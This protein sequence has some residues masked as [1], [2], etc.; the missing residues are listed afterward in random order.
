MRDLEISRRLAT[1]AVTPD[2]V[3]VLGQATL[4]GRAAMFGH[5]LA[6]ADHADP[7]MRA[8]ALWALA[9]ARGV[10]GVRALVRG[11]GDAD[12]A[13]RDAAV[14]GLRATGRDAPHR[15]AHA[16]FHPDVAI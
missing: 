15:Y 3:T 14:A 10:P 7:A 11:L 6:L 2:E 13:V 12:A 5:V 4:A 16:L 8:A 9:G 1:G